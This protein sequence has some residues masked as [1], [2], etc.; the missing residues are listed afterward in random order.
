[1]DLIERY[2]LHRSSSSIFFFNPEH[3]TLMMRARWPAFNG[4]S[5]GA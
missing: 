4:N 1:M 2:P 3:Y 5:V